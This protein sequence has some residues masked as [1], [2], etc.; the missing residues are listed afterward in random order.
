[1]T[2]EVMLEGRENGRSIADILYSGKKL[3]IK[4][5][6][7]FKEK[8]EGGKMHLQVK[9]GLITLINQDADLCD[10]VGKADLKC[11]LDKGEMTLT[12][13]VDLPSQIPPVS[14]PLA[15]PPTKRYTDLYRANTP[16]LQT[17]TTTTGTRSP[18]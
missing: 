11:P 3:T 14:T 5:T 13:D 15:L 12:K 1:M 18:A 9:Y 10:T 2:C 4:A 8:I 16:F 6:G 7:D 17:S